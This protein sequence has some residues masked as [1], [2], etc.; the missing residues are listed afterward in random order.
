MN[1]WVGVGFIFLSA[2][3]FGA[4][5]LFANVAYASGISPSAL[6]F[7]RFGIASMFLW[8]VLLIRHSRFQRLS[9]PPL[10]TI[11][12]LCLMGALG[13]AGL[14][15]SYFT[16]LQYAPAG[17]VAVLLY[18][19][20]AL[21][22]AISALVSKQAISRLK[23]LALMVSLLGIVLIIGIPSG[24]RLIG[25][26]LGIAAA[27]IYALYILVGERVTKGM[28]V[29]LS[30]TIIISS[31]ALVYGVNGWLHGI[32][33]PQTSQAWWAA[34]ALAI[35]ST[36]VAIGAFFEGVQRIGAVDASML[37]TIEPVASVLL[38]WGILGE[39]LTVWGL[40]GGAMI[41]LAAILLARNEPLA[42]PTT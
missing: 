27:V 18:L 39:R 16:A 34:G 29:W 1:R 8:G 10:K 33:W 3:C 13:Y 2:V 9:C 30:S 14:A 25:I 11:F 26:L 15:F 4:M 41:L 32:Q 38:A 6:L 37:S 17:L 22:T 24:G 23:W 36:V 35:V 31:A 21:V 42:E 20:P 5:P 19:Y 7:L 28:D 40:I 12:S